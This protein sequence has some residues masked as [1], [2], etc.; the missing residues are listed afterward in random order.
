MNVVL[1][2]GPGEIEIGNDIAAAIQAP[3]HNFVGKTSIRQMMALID[4]ASLMVT[5]DSGP[6]HVAA[7]FNVPIVAIFGSTDHT[8][9]SPF[10]DRYRIV[11]HD[12]ECSPC[13]LREC[14]IDHR[15]MDRVTVE[16]VIEVV[17]DF[18]PELQEGT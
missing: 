1:I 15:C 3:V 2:G 6:M 4:V 7:G 11:R 14:P 9:T 16:D 12:V 8:T 10:S 5:N 13:M 18:M 17:Q